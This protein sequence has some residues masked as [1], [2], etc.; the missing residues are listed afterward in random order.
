MLPSLVC[1]M[2]IALED[3]A[4]GYQ[5]GYIEL[6]GSGQQSVSYH[7]NFFAPLVVVV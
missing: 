2:V 6:V 4:L 1:Q 7:R 3:S 5:I